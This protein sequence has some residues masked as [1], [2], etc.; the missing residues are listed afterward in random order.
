MGSLVWGVMGFVYDTM[1]DAMLISAT[2]SD[3]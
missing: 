2:V 1:A 3:V